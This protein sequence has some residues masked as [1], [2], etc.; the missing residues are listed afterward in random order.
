M[1]E[2]I[3][4]YKIVLTLCPEGFEFSMGR[5]PKSQGEFDGWARLAEK[6]LLDGHTDWD[7]LLGSTHHVSSPGF[8][9]ATAP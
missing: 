6:G 4:E 3:K 8:T 1:E 5:K 2:E 7:T 9:V